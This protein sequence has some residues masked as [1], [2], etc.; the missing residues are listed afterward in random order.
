M[1][2]G[3]LNNII[4]V[5]RPKV[6]KNEYGANVI[7]YNNI[8]T[9][10]AYIKNNSGNRANENGEIVYNYIKSFTVRYYNDV[11]ET[12]IIIWNNKK[13]RITDIDEYRD[14]QY[15]VINTELIND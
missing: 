4:V 10:R 14:K 6:V 12:D 13:Y 15:K 11:R 3:I 1:Q 9:T 2:A 8:I 5:Q 7:Q